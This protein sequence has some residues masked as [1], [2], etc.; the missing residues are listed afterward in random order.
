MWPTIHRP[1]RTAAPNPPPAHTR[2]SGGD[3]A[4]HRHGG[5]ATEDDPPA[6]Q[7]NELSRL[8]RPPSLR[9][10][11]APANARP[12]PRGVHHGGVHPGM[13]H[14]YR[15][16]GS[17]SPQGRSCWSPCF[18]FVLQGARDPPPHAD[19]IPLARRVARWGMKPFPYSVGICG[20]QVYAPAWP[21]APL[22]QL[23]GARPT[24]HTV[25]W[26]ATGGERTEG[27]GGARAV[28]GWVHPR[29]ERDETL[30]R[31]LPCGAGAQLTPVPFVASSPQPLSTS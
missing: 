16:W 18:L 10:R 25:H 26:G 2:A 11:R 24:V 6:R 14:R 5:G 13:R 28:H 30:I 23:H 3:R 4:A 15:C 21:S 9:G 31:A 19:T 7:T 17:S 22:A 8:T 12:C 1:P 29:W 27:K 20:L